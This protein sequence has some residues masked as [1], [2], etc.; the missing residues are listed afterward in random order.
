[1]ELI[2]ILTQRFERLRGIIQLRIQKI[3]ELE[4][5]AVL[6]FEKGELDA[7]EVLMQQKDSIIT[8]NEQLAL[9]VEKWEKRTAPKERQRLSI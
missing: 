6:L 7:I 3:K 1:M 9:F 2:G 5:Q 4:E 8:T